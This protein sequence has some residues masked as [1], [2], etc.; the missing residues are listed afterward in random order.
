MTVAR[1]SNPASPDD[2][3]PNWITLYPTSFHI[4]NHNRTLNLYPDPAWR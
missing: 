2:L 1:P 4:P 3:Y